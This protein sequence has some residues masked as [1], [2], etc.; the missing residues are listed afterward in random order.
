MLLHCKSFDTYTNKEVFHRSLIF[1][2]C[3]IYAE[4][5]KEFKKLVKKIA[6]YIGRDHPWILEKLYRKLFLYPLFQ[7]CTYI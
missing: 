2:N 3:T 4:I 6:E 7:N 1:F 5:N